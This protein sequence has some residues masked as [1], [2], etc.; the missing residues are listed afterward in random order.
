MRALRRAGIVERL[1]A[2]CWLI[3]N[4]FEATMS[5]EATHQPPSAAIVKSGGGFDVAVGSG[6]LGI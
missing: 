3:P 5:D 1:D 4:D 6:L 2:D